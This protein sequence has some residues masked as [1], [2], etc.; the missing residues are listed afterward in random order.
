M[1]ADRMPS[2]RVSSIPWRVVKDVVKDDDKRFF[3]FRDFMNCTAR[4]I[5]TLPAAPAEKLESGVKD[6]WR[7]RCGL[8]FPG[9]LET[10]RL[11]LQHGQSE[12]IIVARLRVGDLS[13]RLLQL[14]LA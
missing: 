6:N 9:R 1:S 4:R 10:G 5:A 3:R 2:M 11:I 8:L 12:P 7:K 14:R 13:L